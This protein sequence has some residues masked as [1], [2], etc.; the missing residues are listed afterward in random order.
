MKTLRRRLNAFLLSLGAARDGATAVEFAMVALPFMT[1]MFA[2]IELGLVFVLSS[3][4]ET[5]VMDAGRQIRTG[6]LQ[7]GAASGRTVDAFK[8]TVC[9]RM[10]VFATDCTNRLTLD[11][12][13]IP[14]FTNPNPPSPFV[15]SG[16]TTTF[17]PSAMTFVPGNARDIVLVRAWYK[18]PLF[19]PLMNDGLS[20]L[21]DGSAYLSST[22]TFR[23]EPY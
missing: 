3:T 23:N 21:K 7:T 18:H 16:S 9:S 20:R 17:N 12:R 14:Q 22:T 13:V 5:A 6:Q 11:V 10:S 2:I 19:T 8:T 1:M 4:L 15:T